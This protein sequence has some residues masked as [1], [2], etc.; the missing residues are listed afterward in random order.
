MVSGCLLSVGIK[1]SV[2]R[3]GARH[4]AMSGGAA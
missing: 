4:C 2:G 1:I 3:C